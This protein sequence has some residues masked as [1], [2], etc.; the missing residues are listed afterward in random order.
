MNV[1]YDLI[2]NFLRWLRIFLK[3]AQNA[4][5]LRFPL[6][7]ERHQNMCVKTVATNLMILKQCLFIKRKNKKKT[8]AD[9]TPIQMN[10]SSC[11]CLFIILF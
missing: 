2:I 10:K 4:M 9:N 1:L 8:T 3:C 6:E 11:D 7:K 5:V